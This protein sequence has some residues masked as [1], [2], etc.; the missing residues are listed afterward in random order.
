M[1]KSERKAYLVA[2]RARYQ[3]A[4]K[5]AKGLILDEFCAVCGYHRKYALRCESARS[6][7]EAAQA[8]RRAAVDLWRSGDSQAAARDLAGD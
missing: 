8:S 7:A 5:P 2:I 4:N 6:I 3:R 1:G